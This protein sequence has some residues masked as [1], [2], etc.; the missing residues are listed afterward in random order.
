MVADHGDL[1]PA[2]SRPAMT[3]PARSVRPT[4]STQPWAPT[5]FLTPGP[6]LPPPIA[7]DCLD[8]VDALRAAD[9][10]REVRDAYSQRS[11]RERLTAS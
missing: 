4:S 7:D 9:Q 10:V 11:A 3:L 5:S 1:S 6:G 2:A 8:V